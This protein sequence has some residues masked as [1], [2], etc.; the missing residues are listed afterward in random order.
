MLARPHLAVRIPPPTT[1]LPH[2]RQMPQGHTAHALARVGLDVE[3]TR[4]LNALALVHRRRLQR[5]VAPQ[6]VPRAPHVLR[7]HI[8]MHNS[9]KS[10]TESHV[11]RIT[12]RVRCARLFVNFRP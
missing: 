11:R 8:T 2:K 12:A 10:S 4:R 9:R 3:D 7:S 5:D 6:G 1:D